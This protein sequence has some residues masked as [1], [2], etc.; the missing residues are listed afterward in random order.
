MKKLSM[1]FALAILILT[2]AGSAQASITY[3]DTVN[4]G[5]GQAGTYFLPG[6][7]TEYMPPYY[8]WYNQDWGWTH[9]TIAS[10][11]IVGSI[12]WATLE[13]NA[14]DVDPSEVDRIRADGVLL[15]QLVVGDGV[16]KTTT[17]NLDAAALAELMDGTVNITMD[18][19]ATGTS[20]AVTL[21]SAKLTVNYEPYVEPEPDPDPDP[22]PAPVPAPGAVLLGSIG[23]GVVGWLRRRRT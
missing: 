19:D 20:Y 13:I 16:W 22:Q 4:S 9:D 12:N 18:I 15:G 3:V 6:G 2:V 8:R 7:E 14:Y 23:V 1:M 17:F 5:S 11:D 10:G 21:K